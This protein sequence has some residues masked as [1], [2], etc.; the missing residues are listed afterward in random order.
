MKDLINTEQL[1]AQ[2]FLKRNQATANHKQIFQHCFSNLLF[3]NCI[4]FGY[5]LLNIR[6]TN[7][8]LKLEEIPKHKK[9][10]SLAY[11]YFCLMFLVS[12]ELCEDLFQNIISAKLQ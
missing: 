9:N 11:R 5:S 1:W 3:V 2:Q 4:V 10:V 12:P 8:D 6:S 7:R